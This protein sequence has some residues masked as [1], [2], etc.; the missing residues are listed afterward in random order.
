MRVVARLNP[1]LTGF[2]LSLA[3]GLWWF[4][5]VL[6]PRIVQ[7]IAFNH[8][9]HVAEGMEC[10]DCHE[11]VETQRFAGF[12]SLG[13][14]LTCHEDPVTDSPEEERIRTYAEAGQEI[15]WVRLFQQPRHIYYSHRRHVG[16][17]GL[18][19]TR[20]HGDIGAS[21][22]PPVRRPQ[23]LAMDDCID[24]HRESAVRT[25]CTVCHK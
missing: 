18:E 3:V 5:R 7:P 12:P 16:I 20:C 13:V 25:D 21:T 4:P 14:C 24:C 2:V 22:A 6:E 17:A 9:L 23:Q 19:C 11:S 1:L 10:V 15:P 8:Q